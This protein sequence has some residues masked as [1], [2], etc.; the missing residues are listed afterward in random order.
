MEDFDP[1]FQFRLYWLN[2]IVRVTYM[3][4]VYVY[5]FSCLVIDNVFQILKG[6]IY[7]SVANYKVNSFLC[8]KLKDR[9]YQDHGFDTS[10]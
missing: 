4:Q 1:L 6:Y 5:Y 3:T 8:K 9:S 10:C 7:I 2:D